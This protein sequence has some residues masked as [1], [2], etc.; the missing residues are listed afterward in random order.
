MCE[1]PPRPAP[2]RRF[3]GSRFGLLTPTPRPL[4]IPSPRPPRPAP[5]TPEF[6]GEPADAE[7]AAP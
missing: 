1:R 6:D 7:Q 2:V 5:L 3:G 4:T